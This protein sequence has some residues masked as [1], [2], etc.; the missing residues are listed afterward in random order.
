M[1]PAA[2]DYLR[3]SSLEEA[4]QQLAAGGDHAKVIAGGQS[5]GPMLN[6]RLAMPSALI[7]L[8][9]LT[10]LAYIREG[11][12]FLSIGALTRHEQIAGSALV[13]SRCPLLGQAAKTIGHYAIR[14]RGTLGGSLAHAD[15]AA[16]FP[17][18]AMTLGAEI[19]IARQGGSRRVPTQAFFQS[20]MTTALAPDEI[21]RCVHFPTLSGNEGT[22]FELFN[23]RHGDYAIVAVAA[24]VALQDERV[25]R[26]R[27]G[28]SGVSAIPRSCDDT[29]RPLLGQ[30]ANAAWA[31][32]VARVVRAAVAPEDDAGVT[33]VYRKELTEKLVQQA[34]ERALGRAK[35]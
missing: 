25:V 29:V 12:A 21:I 22:S 7:D 17:L 28:L 11:G 9:D 31:A 8:N 27:L 6:M 1:K 20:A 24:T 33:A 32:D 30:L 14:Q 2:F 34:L 18:I 35:G 16:Q 15:P 13:Q 5:L 4:L 23:R 19:E 26:V 3:P 10:E